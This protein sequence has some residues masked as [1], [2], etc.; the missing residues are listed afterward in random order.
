MHGAVGILVK[1]S[2]GKPSG[3]GLGS[4]EAQH[5]AGAWGRRESPARERRPSQSSAA[6]ICS[7]GL[8]RQRLHVKVQPPVTRH[9]AR[10]GHGAAVAQAT[11]NGAR[12][13]LLV[14]GNNGNGPNRMRLAPTPNARG[15][16]AVPKL[17]F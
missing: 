14:G 10:E 1:E 7:P 8:A 6:R 2:R 17:A 9:A 12:G 13:L 16:R 15:V 11:V 3:A 5:C 4:R